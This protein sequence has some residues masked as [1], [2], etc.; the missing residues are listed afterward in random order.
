MVWEMDLVVGVKLGMMVKMNSVS[1]MMVG[2]L[3]EVVM[4]VQ[5][6]LEMGDAP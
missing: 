1:V 5:M 3:E 6:A 2:V 4:A